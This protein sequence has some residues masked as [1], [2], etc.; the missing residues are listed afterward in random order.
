MRPLFSKTTVFIDSTLSRGRNGSAASP[1][2]SRATAP[3][4][5]EMQL[6]L[7]AAAP[8][9]A[10]EPALPRV[11]AGAAG[12]ASALVPVLAAAGTAG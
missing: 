3:T 5:T 9:A 2:A 7:A 12:S 10:P 1:V 6:A 11:L 8:P 4:G